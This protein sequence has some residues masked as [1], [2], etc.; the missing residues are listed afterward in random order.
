MNEHRHLEVAIREHLRDVGQM[1]SYLVPSD[2]VVL[3]F[4][5]HLYCATICKEQEMV[6]GRLM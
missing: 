6:G 3:I 4:R 2:L 1:H 5:A